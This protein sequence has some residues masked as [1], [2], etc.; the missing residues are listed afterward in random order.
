ML[1]KIKHEGGKVWINKKES[2]RGI[3]VSPKNTS[4][5]KFKNHAYIGGFER[6]FMSI[7]IE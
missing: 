5:E 2:T 1:K 7:E 3:D 4:I 6:F